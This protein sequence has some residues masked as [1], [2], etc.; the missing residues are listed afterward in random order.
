MLQNDTTGM[1]AIIGR[2]RGFEIIPLADW[3]R[4]LPSQHQKE[5][6]LRKLFQVL[7]SALF[8][9]LNISI[10]GNFNGVMCYNLF[11]NFLAMSKNVKMTAFLLD[12][13]QPEKWA[14]LLDR[15][16]VM[17]S[18]FYTPQEGFHG[19]IAIPGRWLA[20]APLNYYQLENLN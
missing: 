15:E 13:K 14:P 4:A 5:S 16:K 2:R 3:L 11:L 6:P 19:P 17:I 18:S 9:G 20:V 12:Q 10:Q 7:S 8:G 1:I